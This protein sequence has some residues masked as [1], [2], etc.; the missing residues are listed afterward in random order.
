MAVAA[1]A[2]HDAL[3]SD[4]RDSFFLLAADPS[5][6]QLEG[7][8]AAI[9]GTGLP[10]LLFGEE[11]SGRTSAAHA[12]HR[13][14]IGSDDG[15]V[16]LA[17][18]EATPESLALLSGGDRESKDLPRTLLLEEVGD[19]NANSQWR[20]LQL[21]TGTPPPAC[22]LIATTRK[23]L[24]VEVHAGRFR[25]DL[26]Y[27]LNGVSLSVPPLR[28]RKKDLAGFID[29]F[30]TKYA[31]LF[32]RPK[33]ELSAAARTAL[34][35]YSW[36]GNLAELENTIRAIVATDDEQ[37][38]LLALRRPAARRG[39]N[40]NGEST[41]LKQAA[42]A[43][44]QHAERELIA[45]TLARTQGNRKRAAAELQISYKALLYKLKQSGLGNS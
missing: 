41:S 26:L 31:I 13:M 39:R 29:F 17:A 3:E 36:P 12:I 33:P 18:V 38:A 25:E 43:A 32:H 30:L 6:Q 10:V 2:P 40:G 24:D 23:N 44:S 7:I 5:M 27:C 28:H 9:A 1:A 35:E 42:R 20:L 14:R 15:L 19:L 16:M 22:R 11:G 4:W 45:K 34:L 8:F 21:M 37:L